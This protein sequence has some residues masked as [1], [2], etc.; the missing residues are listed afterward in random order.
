MQ[1]ITIDP[2][3]L[4]QIVKL[5]MKDFIELLST[6]CSSCQERPNQTSDDQLMASILL[7][8]ATQLFERGG[9]EIDITI[10]N[11]EWGNKQIQ[12]N[13]K[14]LSHEYNPH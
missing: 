3:V 2:N 10:A 12:H 13:S 5:P 8:Y 14:G 7:G 11:K 4:R 6:I 1:T 9:C